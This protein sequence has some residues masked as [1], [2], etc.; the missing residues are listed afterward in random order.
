VTA[1]RH[2]QNGYTGAFLLREVE[3]P[4][5]DDAGVGDESTWDSGRADVNP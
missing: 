5:Q 4:L 2:V 3:H 1:R